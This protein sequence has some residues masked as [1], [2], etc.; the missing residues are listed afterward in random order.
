MVVVAPTKATV[1]GSLFCPK[2]IELKKII[3]FAKLDTTRSQINKF[4]PKK[5]RPF[6]DNFQT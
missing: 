1:L 6:G 5:I 2:R 3:K 4:L